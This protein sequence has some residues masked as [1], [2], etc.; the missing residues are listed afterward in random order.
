MAQYT[1]KLIHF[2]FFD[3]KI[4]SLKTFDIEYFID[5]L[6]NDFVH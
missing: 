4:N 3:R 5:I 1:E 2:F 6:K